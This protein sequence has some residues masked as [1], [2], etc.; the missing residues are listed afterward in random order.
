M[1]KDRA[2]T[3]IRRNHR[4][5]DGLKAPGNTA[6]PRDSETS[7]RTATL[8]MKC[9]DRK[10]LVRSIADFISSNGG[11]ILHA[12]HHID[13]ETHHFF[14]RVEWEID[15]FTIPAGEIAASFRPLAEAS[16]M[17]WQLRFS[18]EHPAVAIFVSTLD[19]C[20]VDL[21]HRWS[22]GELPGSV[23][24]V[25]SNHPDLR[26]TVERQGI[27]YHHF[28]ITLQNKRAQ[29]AKQ[30]ELLSSLG[31]DLVI[32]AR[33]MQVVSDEFIPCYPNR[34]INIHHSFLPAFI[35]TDPFVS[36]ADLR[37]VSGGDCLR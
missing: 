28:P 31:V 30:L 15:E 8:L 16:A 23:V 37:A 11:N 34:I 22:I 25:V 18:D 29:K 13:F 12:D 4:G 21:L 7:A 24:A 33:Y 2:T 26:A 36:G 35:I 27:P 20:L 9:P 32:F 1:P 3:L 10:G 5:P 14:S 17:E 6:M 19:H